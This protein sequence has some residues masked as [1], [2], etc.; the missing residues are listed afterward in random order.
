MSWYGSITINAL[1]CWDS[2]TYNSTCTSTSLGFLVP[3]LSKRQETTRTKNKCWPSQ[4]LWMLDIPLLIGLWFLM[5]LTSLYLNSSLLPPLLLNTSSYCGGFWF[6]CSTNGH[7][8]DKIALDRQYFNH[9]NCSVNLV[10]SID[11]HGILVMLAN[12]SHH[13]Y[14]SYL[15]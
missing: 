3:G 4:L 11:I 7:D 6:G 5:A 8:H 10:K 14:C 15:I 13:W 9:G 12:R 2:P 1:T